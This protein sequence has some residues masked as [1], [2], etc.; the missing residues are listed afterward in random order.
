MIKEMMNRKIRT[1]QNF[2]LGQYLKKEKRGVLSS[3]L[4]LFKAKL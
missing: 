1:I 2:T 3:P 4:Y